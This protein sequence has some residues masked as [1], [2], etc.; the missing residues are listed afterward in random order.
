MGIFLYG[1]AAK[2]SGREPGRFGAQILSAADGGSRIIGG[3][4]PLKAWTHQEGPLKGQKG[5]YLDGKS[6]VKQLIGWF[7]WFRPLV[8]H[9]GA[10]PLLRE[11][12]PQASPAAEAA[13]PLP[14]LPG[15]ALPPS[16]AYLS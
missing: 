12:P 2:K 3:N 14:T 5:C 13:F 4:G 9:F 16:D 15:P 8:P 11:A 6:S 7:K 10:I 1:K